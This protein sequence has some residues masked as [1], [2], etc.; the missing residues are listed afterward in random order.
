MEIIHDIKSSIIRSYSWMPQTVTRKPKLSVHACYH[1]NMILLFQKIR[2]FELL[3]RTFTIYC[4]NVLKCRNE[5]KKSI[6]L[7]LTVQWFRWTL[8]DGK[9]TPSYKKWSKLGAEGVFCRYLE[10]YGKVLL[11]VI[12]IENFNRVLKGFWR[13]SQKLHDLKNF[14][15]KRTCLQSP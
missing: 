6:K 2:D 3:G 15:R 5:G 7:C 4:L 14:S 11:R 10:S 9:E 13:K 12:L 1:E 8:V